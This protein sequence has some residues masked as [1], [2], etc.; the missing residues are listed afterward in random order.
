MPVR[1]SKKQTL[2]AYFQA[3]EK[4]PLEARDLHAAQS[5]LHR[6]LGPGDRTSLG[7]IATVLRE[8]GYRGPV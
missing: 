1:V 4:K 7:Y 3:Q 5:E 2:L 8:A 6:H